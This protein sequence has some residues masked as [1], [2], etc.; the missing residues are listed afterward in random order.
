LAKT[1][2]QQQKRNTKIV[3]RCIKIL[4]NQSKTQKSLG[5]SA[6]RYTIQESEHTDKCQQ[7][8]DYLNSES[9]TKS[10]F[11]AENY[12]KLKKKRAQQSSLGVYSHSLPR[13]RIDMGTD[14]SEKGIAIA[15]HPSINV[16]LRIRNGHFP[17][18][19]S[20]RRTE[21][22]KWIVSD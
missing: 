18:T 8:E 1:R 22:K 3:G 21:R 12:E 10:F 4:P 13:R 20:K 5:K 17:C 16:S 2:V 11:L 19:K 6:G 9:R 14:L 15:G 7:R